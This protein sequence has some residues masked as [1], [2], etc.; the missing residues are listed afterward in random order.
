MSALIPQNVLLISEQKLKNFTDIDQNV[1]TAVLLPFISIFVIMGMVSLY[2][3][4][5]DKEGYCGQ[6][7][8]CCKK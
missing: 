7:Q 5:H 4:K 6:K 8:G 3:K 1:T 2:Q